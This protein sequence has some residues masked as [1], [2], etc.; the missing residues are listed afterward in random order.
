MLMSAAGI[1]GSPTP[2]IVADV[3]LTLPKSLLPVK[4]DRSRARFPTVMFSKNIHVSVGVNSLFAQN[5][6]IA[7][8]LKC[9]VSTRF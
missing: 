2:E 9:A 6:M 8:C 4:N 3:R 1:T 7:R 5:F